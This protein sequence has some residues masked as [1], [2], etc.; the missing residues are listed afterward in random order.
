[1]FLQSV[2]SRCNARLLS[3]SVHVTRLSALVSVFFKMRGKGSIVYYPIFFAQPFFFLLHLP[4][5][6][7]TLQAT[8]KWYVSAIEFVY[9]VCTNCSPLWAVS[10]LRTSCPVSTSWRLHG[11]LKT[12]HCL[13]ID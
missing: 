2:Q 12:K 13:F 6:E 1:M 3:V 10:V 4:L 7:S 8:H 9:S 11:G 5:R